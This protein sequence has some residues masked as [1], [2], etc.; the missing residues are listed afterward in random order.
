MAW[1]ILKEKDPE[2]YKDKEK[3][4]DVVDEFNQTFPVDDLTA[5][6]QDKWQQNSASKPELW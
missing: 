4:E 1:A 5:K 3:I 6:R 2:K